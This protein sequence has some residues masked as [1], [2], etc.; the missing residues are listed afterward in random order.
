M[1]KVTLC[2]LRRDNEILL[3]L[4]KRGFGE[5]KWNGVGG[6]VHEGELLMDAALRELTEEIGVIASPE[7]LEEVA[8]IEFSFPENPE[9]DQHMYIF[10][11]H[12]WQ[13]EPKESE[14]MRPQWFA[15]D[16]IPYD[17]MWIDDV[18]WLPLVLEG[19]KVKGACHFKG[20]GSEI[21]A[22]ELSER[23]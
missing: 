19:K 1:R 17:N 14:E 7:H 2:F 6:K 16:R 10:F 20:D 8:D 18:H 9:F 4:K 13:G 15:L 3:A 23:L 21:E 11:V 5:G 12:E 22:F